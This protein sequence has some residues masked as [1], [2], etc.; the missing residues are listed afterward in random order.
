M[1]A[2]LSMWPGRPMPTIATFLGVTIKL[3]PNDH[4]PAH[5]HAFHGDDE[6]MVGIAGLK[7]LAGQLPRRG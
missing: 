5:F 6:V 3:Y 1:E 7:V 4:Q 2:Y